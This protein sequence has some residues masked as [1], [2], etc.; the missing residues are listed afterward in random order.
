[1]P[2]EDGSPEDP[3]FVAAI[4]LLERTGIASFGLRYQ[5]DEEPTVWIAVVEYS[6]EKT[7]T[8]GD[9][10]EAAAAMTPLQAILRLCEQ[11]IDGGKC[12]HCHRT[13]AIETNWRSKL[14]LEGVVCWYVYDP[15][16]QKF[17]RDCEGEN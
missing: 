7:P 8:I 9:G 13:C 17:R 4:K 6:A 14:P 1:M 11:V 15:E 12:V 3:R 5:D 16:T 10:A 2:R